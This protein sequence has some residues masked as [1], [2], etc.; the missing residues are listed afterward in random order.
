MPFSIAIHSTFKLSWNI[1]LCIYFQLTCGFET[2]PPFN[3]PILIIKNNFICKIC[4]DVSKM[5]CLIVSYAKIV[6]KWFN[7]FFVFIADAQQSQLDDKD[8]TIRIQQNLITKLEAEVDQ[9]SNG[10][11]NRQQSE[12]MVD[13][14][15][16]ATQTDR[17][18]SFLYPYLI[19]HSQVDCK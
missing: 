1:I 9:V 16:T 2:F 17:V 8:R 6:E 5:I 10:N 7:S 14:S 3:Y 4:S 15:N 11:Q 13:T 18:S 12:Q 19:I